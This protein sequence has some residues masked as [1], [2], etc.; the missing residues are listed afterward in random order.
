[1]PPGGCFAAAAA[2]QYMGILNDLLPNADKQAA[3]FCKK[4]T[5]KP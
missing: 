5:K 2:G 4:E 3:V 1:M